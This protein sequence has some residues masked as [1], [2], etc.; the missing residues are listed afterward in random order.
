MQLIKIGDANFLSS[1]ILTLLSIW[2]IFSGYFYS[3]LKYDGSVP[4]DR[5]VGGGLLWCCL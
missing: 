2:I 5:K 4:Q 1:S 3:V